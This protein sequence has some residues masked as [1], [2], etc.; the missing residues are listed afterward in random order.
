MPWTKLVA[1]VVGAGVLSS[2]T[3]W[4]FAGDWIHKRFTYPEI[5]RKGQESRA[6]ALTSPLPFIT[7]GV[8]AAL[9]WY[10]DLRSVPGAARLAVA[11]WVIGPLPLI[12][13]NA[14]FIKMHRVFVS[15]YAI[16]WLVKL[17]IAAVAVGLF[18]R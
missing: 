2:L 9:A 17:M 10:L 12:L 7:C 15:C 8:F 4:I 1:I 6:I 5:W 18:L 3:D 14:A 11:I 16:G 13:T